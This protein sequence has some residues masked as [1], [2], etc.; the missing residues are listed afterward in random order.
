M[1]LGAFQQGFQRRVVEPAQH[2]Y[3]RARQHGTIQLERRIFGGGADQDDGAVFHHGKKRILLAAVEAV[4][5][6]HEQQ[7]ALPHAAAQARGVE[8]FLEV[9]NARKHSRK[10]LEMEVEGGGKQPRDSGLAGAGRSPQHD[11]MRPVR[12]HHPPDGPFG[13]DQVILAHD[14]GQRFR[15]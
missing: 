3:L 6:V 7:R 5:F 14:L 8:G 2:Q 9:G 15:T 13:P 11:G 4:D 1:R 12:R 10:L